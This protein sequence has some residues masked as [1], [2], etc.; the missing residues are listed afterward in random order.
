M[1]YGDG[2]GWLSSS[3]LLAHSV[4]EACLF[5]GYLSNVVFAPEAD[6]PVAFDSVDDL[7]VVPLAI[8][9]VVEVEGEQVVL[10]EAPSVLWLAREADLP[11]GFN[12]RSFWLYG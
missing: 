9:G 5:D 10:H 6:E 7:T 12:Q 11:V 3:S 8:L 2:E 1:K 4:E